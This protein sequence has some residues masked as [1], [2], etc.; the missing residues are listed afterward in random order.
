MRQNELL[1]RLR[2]RRLPR[3]AA[4]GHARPRDADLA[5]RA[6]TTRKDAPNENYAREL[7]ELFTL[8]AGRG[9][10]ERDVREQA[11][12][13]TGFRNDWDD[14]VGPN[15]FR[16]DAERPRPRRQAHLR[17]ARPL[18][19]ARRLRA[20]PRP[21]EPP[22]A[23]S[24]PSC[25]A[26][27]SRRRRRAARARALRA[28][29]PAR[30]LRRRP[31]VEAILRHPLFYHGP[32]MVKPPVVYI[33]GLLRALGRGIDTDAWVWLADMPASS[34]STRRTWPAGTTTA[35]STP[36]TWR[37]RWMAAIWALE[38]KALDARQG[39]AAAATSSRARPS[40]RALDFWG[41]P[42]ISSATR[43]SLESFAKRADAAADAQVEAGAVPVL[44]PERAAHAGRHLSRPPD[45]LMAHRCCDDFSRTELLRRGRLGRRALPAIEPGHAA[46]GG[47]R[48]LAA[49]LPARARPALALSVYGA[50]R[51]QPG[52][53]RG[54]RRR[55][56]AAGPRSRCWSRSSSPAASTRVS[57]LAPTGDPRLSQAAADAGARAEPAARRSP[58]TRAC[59]G[60][61]SRRRSRRCTAR[62]R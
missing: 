33:A 23:S 60:T 44:T 10:S 30:A 9:Y 2:A 35:G 15:N 54:G 5:Q 31:V 50:A 13:L 59:A 42:L 6:P 45:L 48:A 57:V 17:Q 43:A 11:R 12:A 22:V 29:L 56:A 52:R 38:G 37:G 27:S 3:A 28:A 41:G 21:P 47:Q 32:R 53:V 58:R 36:R 34:S 40:Q 46:A 24:S 25:G 14:G 51:L 55:S 8:G 16:F 20:L 39:H 18:R 19:L 26:T 4:G 49:R 62:A 7:M 61:P 1:R